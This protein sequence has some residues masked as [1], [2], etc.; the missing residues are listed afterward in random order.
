MAFQ[1]ITETAPVVSTFSNLN[2]TLCIELQH[3][4][5]PNMLVFLALIS[6]ILSRNRES[7]ILARNMESPILA[8]NMELPISDIL[9]RNRE[10][11][12][13]AFFI[14]AHLGV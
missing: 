11:P 4:V 12:D 7:P 10:S 2:K 5:Y 13:T 1:A 6:D 3:N 14:S 9:S 8:R